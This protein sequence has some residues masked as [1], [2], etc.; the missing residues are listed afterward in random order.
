MD[1][2]LEYDWDTHVIDPIQ[3]N[4]DGCETGVEEDWQPD[5]VDD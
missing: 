1:S 5:A 4:D 3:S 2:R